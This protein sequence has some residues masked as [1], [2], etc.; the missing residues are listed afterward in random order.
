MLLSL[1]Q[2]SQYTSFAKLPII[3]FLLFTGCAKGDRDI[4]NEVANIDPYFIGY[5][6]EL[7]DYII[8]ISIP[9]HM[10]LHT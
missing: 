9:H 7:S 2:E 4:A 6:L 10:K 5:E 3:I 8:T 1:Y